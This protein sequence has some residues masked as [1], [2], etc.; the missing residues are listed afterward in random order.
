MTAAELWK[1]GQKGW[2]RRFPLVQAP[3]PPL[4]AAV[5]GWAVAS[6]STGGVR[7][8]SRAISTVGLGVWAV[9]EVVAGTNWF[10][11]L[12]GA[13]AVALLGTQLAGSR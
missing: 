9:E 10:R 11:R 7:D 2:P 6:R 8:V 1:R 4:M 13:G 12:L 5:A 3:N